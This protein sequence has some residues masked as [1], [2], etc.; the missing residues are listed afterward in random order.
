M[1]VARQQPHHVLCPQPQRQPVGEIG[2]AVDARRNGG[3]VLVGQ[4]ILRAAPGLDFGSAQ[5]HQLDTETGIEL[6]E[7]LF[8]E[9]HQFR[10]VA[11]GTAGADR[12]AVDRTVD[13]VEGDLELASTHTGLL[14]LPAERGQETAGGGGNILRPADRLGKGQPRAEGRR[15]TAR[16]DR[17]GERAQRLVEAGERLV[18]EAAGEWC[19]RQRIEIADAAQP[20]LEEGFQGRCVEAQ[21]LD[22]QGR[23][24]GTLAMARAEEVG[25]AFGET[26][27]RPGGTRGI[28]HR[29]AAVEIVTHEPSG[30]IGQQSA[31]AG[32]VSSEKMRAAGD[33]E[34]QAGIA[35]EPAGAAGFRAVFGEGAAQRVDRHPGGVAVAPAGDRLD[36]ATIGLRL[37]GQGDEVGQQGARIGQPHVRPQ[38]RGM[39]MVVDRGET[40]AAIVPHDGGGRFSRPVVRRRTLARTRQTIRGELGEPQR[41][42]AFH[43]STPRARTEFQRSTVC[44]SGCA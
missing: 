18:A 38:A 33:V 22:R 40:R 28:G 15:C 14:E 35:A 32:F 36:Q 8:E 3:S 12:R 43:R 41:D 17:L 34:Q 21:P 37:A 26:G 30:Q 20:E 39:G 24:R 10:I 4:R 27:Q 31:F 1:A 2:R 23:E 5:D 19:P 16:L 13:A 42:N 25:L 6:A 11:V 9:L 7:L 44:R 29:G